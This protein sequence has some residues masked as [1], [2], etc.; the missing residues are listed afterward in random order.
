MKF[1]FLK[2]LGGFLIGLAIFIAGCGSEQP[3]QDTPPRATFVPAV[4]F[5]DSNTVYL[6]ES[7]PGQQGNILTL[8]VQGF[9]IN[10]G[11]VKEAQF[12]IDFSGSVV[13]FESFLEGGVVGA[14][15][16]VAY[17]IVTKPENPNRVF[18]SISRTV[19][20]PG[21]SG[22]GIFIKLRFKMVG[23]G[24]SPLSFSESKLIQPNGQEIVGFILKWFGGAIVNTG[25]R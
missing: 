25:S 16:E 12:N 9:D 15:D 4:R 19:N 8:E 17:D 11:A 10:L 1:N 23:I 20:D 3:G 7:P 22:S 14:E 5:P 21:K 18:I 24:S 6:V 13:Q 2:T